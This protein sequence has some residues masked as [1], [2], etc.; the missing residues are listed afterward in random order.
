VT[1]TA[2]PETFI[3][4]MTKAISSNAD[5]TRTIVLDPDG[6]AI[7][8]FKNAPHD[9]PAEFLV[10]SKL[11][12]LASPIFRAMLKPNLM[13]GKAT[14]QGNRP[15]F[16]LYEDDPDAMGPILRVLHFRH[17]GVD[18]HPKP[19]NLAMIAIHSNKYGTTVGL[20]PWV[21]IWIEDMKKRVRAPWTSG[22][23]W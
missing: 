23:H 16:N 12:S 5:P 7:L 21:H 19:K 9:T 15:C 8:R 22:S 3:P 18:M 4:K 10:S 14:R 20:L 1:E 2:H 17:E 11:L 13:E 6:D